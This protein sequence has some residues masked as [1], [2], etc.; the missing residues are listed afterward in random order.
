[1]WNKCF[2]W[3]KV[4]STSMFYIPFC[5]KF[6]A[7]FKFDVSFSFWVYLDPHSRFC[8]GICRNIQ[9]KIEI[10]FFLNQASANKTLISYMPFCR[11][12]Y[13]EFK[14]DVSYSFW[15]Y[16]DPHSRFCRG[17]FHLTIKH[18]IFLTEAQNS[19]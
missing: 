1:M 18:D 13:A 17:M 9:L 5:R 19:K 15:V 4:T 7:K 8:R 16:L 10:Y 6:Y 11:K 3:N 2:I 14:F 12:F